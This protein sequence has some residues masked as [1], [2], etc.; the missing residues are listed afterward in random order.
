MQIADMR[1]SLCMHENAN[2]FGKVKVRANSTLFTPVS[3]Q[4]DY[5]RVRYE[6][7]G[8][9]KKKKGGTYD[10]EGTEHDRCA[11]TLEEH[12]ETCTTCLYREL[13]TRGD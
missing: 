12:G 2:L 8:E 11:S 7:D 6:E 3:S 4:I 5:D 1:H 10:R 13:L 9:K